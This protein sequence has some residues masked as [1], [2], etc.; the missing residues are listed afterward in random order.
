MIDINISF[1][2]LKFCLARRRFENKLFNA[3][4]IILPNT[5]AQSKTA[6]TQCLHRSCT[7]REYIRLEH[8]SEVNSSEWKANS[9]RKRKYW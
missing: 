6:K 7:A 1:I 9:N 5:H 4:Y 8:V 2:H 3:K